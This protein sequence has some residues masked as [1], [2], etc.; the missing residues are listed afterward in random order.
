MV[1]NGLGFVPTVLVCLGI[2]AAYG[3]FNG[4]VITRRLERS[5]WCAFRAEKR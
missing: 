4:F 1:K 2:G 3:L 5:G